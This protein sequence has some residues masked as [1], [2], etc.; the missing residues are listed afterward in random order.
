MKAHTSDSKLPTRS[1]SLLDPTL[2][3]WQS[4]TLEIL[5]ASIKLSETD[6]DIQDSISLSQK[7]FKPVSESYDHRSTSCK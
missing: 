5:G 1:Q 2:I 4:V 3:M 6:S 7:E